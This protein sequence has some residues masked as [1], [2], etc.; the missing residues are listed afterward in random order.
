MNLPGTDW[1]AAYDYTMADLGA[2]LSC[3]QCRALDLLRGIGGND[4]AYSQGQRMACRE[5]MRKP[6]G[7]GKP[8]RMVGLVDVDHTSAEYRRAKH[9][10]WVQAD[11]DETEFGGTE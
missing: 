6:H 1:R 9:E 3:P 4:D 8:T 5:I 7:C 11:L 10:R 2:S